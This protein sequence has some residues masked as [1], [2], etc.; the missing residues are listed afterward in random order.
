MGIDVLQRSGQRESPH[1]LEIPVEQDIKVDG[2]R[3]GFGSGKN[4]ADEL[5]EA[6]ARLVGFL[7][8]K[9]GLFCQELGLARSHASDVPGWRLGW[10]EL[11]FLLLILDLRPKVVASELGACARKKIKQFDFGAMGIKIW[12]GLAP[13]ACVPGFYL[14]F[15]LLQGQQLLLSGNRSK[16]NIS[17]GPKRIALR[18]GNDKKVACE[19]SHREHADSE[20]ADELPSAWAEAGIAARDAQLLS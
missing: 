9:F 13:N 15:S 14:V 19:L 18:L 17:D 7:P 10:N 5:F 2:V 12:C 4:L 8:R 11:S 20:L 1:S 16:N 6:G 3:S